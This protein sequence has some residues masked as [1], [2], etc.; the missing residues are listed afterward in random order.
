MASSSFAVY[1]I[2]DNVYI[3]EMLKD[4]IPQF[5]Q[6]NSSWFILQYVFVVFVIWLIATL[7]D[8]IR[9]N[10]FRPINKYLELRCV[11]REINKMYDTVD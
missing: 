9:Q 3:R 5:I 2:H 8:F 10:L 11:D 6:T 1:L 7:I 4:V